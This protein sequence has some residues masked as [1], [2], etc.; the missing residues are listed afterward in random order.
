MPEI[1]RLPLVDADSDD[2]RLRTV[3]ERS[4]AS[5]GRLSNLYRTLGHAPELLEAWIAFAWPLRHDCLTPRSI[6]E[7]VILRIAHLDGVEYEYAQHLPMAIDAGVDD[8]QIRCLPDWRAAPSGTYSDEACAALA[9]ADRI[10]RAESIDD[11][12][13]AT[14]HTAFG[15]RGALEIVLTASFYVCV[16]RVLGSLRVSLEGEE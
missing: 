8:V 3:F 1:P 9:V 11:D 7:L 2:P 14:M 4:R 5:V 15:D 12:E 13:W 6:R 16:G 10:A